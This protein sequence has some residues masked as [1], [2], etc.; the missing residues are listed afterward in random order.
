[1]AS[2]SRIIVGKTRRKLTVG[3]LDLRIMTI[4]DAAEATLEGQVIPLI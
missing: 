2:P 3:H 1:M 4:F